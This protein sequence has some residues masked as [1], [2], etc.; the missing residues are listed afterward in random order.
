MVKFLVESLAFI[1]FT[2]MILFII[3]RISVAAYE[4]F[5]NFWKGKK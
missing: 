2:M 1:L 3:I 4:S 5:C